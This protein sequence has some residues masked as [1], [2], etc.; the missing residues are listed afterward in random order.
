MYKKNKKNLLVR[1]INKG[2]QPSRRQDAETIYKP[3]GMVYVIKT[4]FLENKTPIPTPKMGYVFVDK[5]TSIN[6]DDKIDVKLANL[7]WN[8]LNVKNDKPN[9]SN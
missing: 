8:E 3:N 2:K 4:D 1:Y 9:K 7:T 6:I 5:N